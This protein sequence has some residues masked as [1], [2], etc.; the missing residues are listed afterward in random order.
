MNQYMSAGIVWGGAADSVLGVVS[1][2]TKGSSLPPRQVLHESLVLGLHY[3][4]LRRGYPVR[5]TW[6]FHVSVGDTDWT[7]AHFLGPLLGRQAPETEVE[8]LIWGIGGLTTAQDGL[9]Q[10]IQQHRHL[11][12]NSTIIQRHCTVG[13]RLQPFLAPW[14]AFSPP[15]VTAAMRTLV[16]LIFTA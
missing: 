9:Y 2:E 8:I 10:L 1:R 12:F 3:M 5:E 7:W 4:R 13:P 11:R 6:A 16:F 14:I 15:A